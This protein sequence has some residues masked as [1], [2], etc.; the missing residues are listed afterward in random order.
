MFVDPKYRPEDFDLTYLKLVYEELEEY[1]DSSIETI[2]FRYWQ[3]REN[4]D[5]L[6]QKK[7]ESAG[8]EDVVLEYY[9]ST[10]QY[11]Y[12]LSHQDATKNYQRKFSIVKSLLSINNMEKMLDYGG[13]IGGLT[14][15][16]TKS[17]YRCDYLDVAGS[18]TF[19]YAKY[20]FQKREINCNM[21]PHNVAIEKLPKSN[22]DLIT[23][24]DC[25]EHVF[26]LEETI[27]RIAYMLKNNGIFLTSSTF[28]GGKIHLLRNNKYSDIK[29]FNSLLSKYCLDFESRYL[30]YFFLPKSLCRIMLKT[31]LRTYFSPSGHLLLY[32]K[33]R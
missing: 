5:S 33:R 7:V 27:E 9:Q 2:G 20:R 26:D 4:Q 3:A 13:G 32:R 10:K 22:Y 19:E 18:Y 16:I 31:P 30:K 8:N 21:I 24:F 14:I 23:S 6:R 11:L 1:L 28:R 12:E 25:L 29:T 15:F 17:E